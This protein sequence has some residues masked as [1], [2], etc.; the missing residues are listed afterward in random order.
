[1]FVTNQPDDFGICF[2]CGLQSGAAGA[3]RWDFCRSFYSDLG[4]LS[5]TRSALYT[6]PI[7]VLFGESYLALRLSNAALQCTE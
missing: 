2:R 4:T 5:W 6:F 1:V 3:I 7:G